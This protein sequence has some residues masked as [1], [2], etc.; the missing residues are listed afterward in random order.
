MRCTSK[1]THFDKIKKNSYVNN[2]DYETQIE[3]RRKDKR[4]LCD[5]ADCWLQRNGFNETILSNYTSIHD[6]NMLRLFKIAAVVHEIN[7]ALEVGT[8]F[9]SP[10]I[11][12]LVKWLLNVKT[13]Q[14]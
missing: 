10:G 8:Q 6:E 1:V 13:F 14:L 2:S 3:Y 4:K 11:I 5:E 9:P 12:I 7:E